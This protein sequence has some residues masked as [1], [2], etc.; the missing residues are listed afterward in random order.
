MELESGS[1]KTGND[2]ITTPS[3]SGRCAERVEAKLN[4]GKTI[5]PSVNLPWSPQSI[6]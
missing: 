3:T 5:S 6:T 4:I 2:A 1:A